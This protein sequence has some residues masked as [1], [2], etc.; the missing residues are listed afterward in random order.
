MM[1]RHFGVERAGWHELRRPGDQA[2]TGERTAMVHGLEDGAGDKPLAQVRVR[3]P[4]YPAIPWSGEPHEFLHFGF[5]DGHAVEGAP[6]Q[7]LAGLVVGSGEREDRRRP[8][9]HRRVDGV[10][11]V[12]AHDRQHRQPVVAQPVHPSDE[13]VHAGPVLVVHLGQLTGLCEGVRLVHLRHVPV[14]AVPVRRAGARP[15]GAAGDAVC[16]GEGTAAVLRG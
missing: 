3:A 13:G 11:S 4:V 12:R 16:G 5:A 2:L 14:G 8:A 9:P 15:A 6:E 10:D 7:I 1:P